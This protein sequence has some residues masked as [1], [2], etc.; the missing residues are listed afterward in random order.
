MKPRDVLNAIVIAFAELMVLSVEQR[1]QEHWRSF[2]VFW[3][4]GPK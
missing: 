3:T 1:T 2:G 4:K